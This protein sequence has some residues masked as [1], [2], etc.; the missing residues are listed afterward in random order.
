MKE[1][2]VKFRAQIYIETKIYRL[3]MST[4]PI[5]EVKNSLETMDEIIAQLLKIRA[6]IQDEPKP[7]PDIDQLK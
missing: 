2:L 6:S 4:P 1:Q 3:K 5:L 7:S